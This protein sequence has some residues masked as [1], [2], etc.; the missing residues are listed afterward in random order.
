MKLFRSYESLA[1]RERITLFTLIS[2]TAL[3]LAFIFYNSLLPP[4]ASGEE[5]AAVGGFLSLLLPEGAWIT[6]FILENLRSL[7]HFAEFFVLGALTAAMIHLFS[8]KP[9][10]LIFPSVVFGLLVGF[11]DETV[12][13][14]SG[15]GP[16]IVDVWV[17]TLGYLTATLAVL[18]IWLIARRIQGKEKGK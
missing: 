3:S 9:A 11:F 18:L 12:Q 5:S 15:R 14:F 6:E 13:I 16:E 1:R 2:L 4:A 8:Y 10:V 7:A 17:D